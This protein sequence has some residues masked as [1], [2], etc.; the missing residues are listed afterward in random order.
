M[1][2]ELEW[3]REITRLYSAV[4]LERSPAVAHGG[5]VTARDRLL[6]EHPCSPADRGTFPGLEVPDHDEAWRVEVPLLPAPPRRMPGPVPGEQVGLLRTPW[7]EVPVWRL[8]GH[9][10]GIWI[11]VRDR[12]SGRLSCAAGRVLY[13]TAWGVDLGTGPDGGLVV[14]LNFLHAPDSAHDPRR[15][16]PQLP[17]GEA[18]DVVVPVGELLPAPAPG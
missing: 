18:L 14:D 11:A 3:R 9:G 5:W 17:P 2:D 10:A 16:G 8:D 12:G 6:A 13:D 7:G 4:R 15:V 1:L